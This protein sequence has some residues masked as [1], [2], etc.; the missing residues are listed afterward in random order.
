MK[1][2][3]LP[4]INKP[5]LTLS[6]ILLLSG[7][8]TAQ[9][10]EATTPQYLQ[11]IE[12]LLRRADI[13]AFGG[14]VSSNYYLAKART[15]LDLAL[16]ES[17]VLDSSEAI[18]AAIEQ[19]ETL[20]DT[21]ERK[22]TDMSMDTPAQISGSEA[23]RPDLWDR[24]AALK[25]HA[26]FSCGQRQIAEAEVYLVWTG[27]EK[28]EYGWSHAES[29][30]RIAENRITEAQEA[31]DNCADAPAAVPVVASVDAPAAALAIPSPPLENITLSGD[32][33]FDYGKATLNPSALWHLDKLL[34]S[35]RQL[36][37]L[38]EV[39]LVGHTDR[40]RRDGRQERNLILSRQRAE[41][42][43]QYLI[44]KGIAADRIHASGVGSTQPLV[45][46]PAK[47]SRK[48]QIACLQPNRRVEITLRGNR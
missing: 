34:D 45:K 14:A 10:A 19:A 44:D 7:T 27:H 30:A 26:T 28:A 13:L 20:L 31:I 6:L 9:S 5:F 38:E 18:S 11:R 16:S 39:A 8:S 47:Q 24:I 4:S 21:L 40:L 23:V 22:Q 33:M 41:S 17:Y 15:W 2:A 48:K 25:S 3:S 1:I 43:K 35:I 37:S 12:A 29:Y 32:T 36:T 46:C 42:I